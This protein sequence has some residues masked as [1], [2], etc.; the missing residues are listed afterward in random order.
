MYTV[1][2]VHLS[3]GSVDGRVGCVGVGV[4]GGWDGQGVL[5]CRFNQSVSH[6]LT[7]YVQHYPSMSEQEKLKT[8]LNLRLLSKKEVEEDVSNYLYL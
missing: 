3:K 2:L 1:C 8:I 6:V 7:K 5:L 4:G